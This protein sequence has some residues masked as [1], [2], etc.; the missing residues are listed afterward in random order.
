M[1]SLRLSGGAITH[2]Q[3][4][5]SLLRE[6]R[7]LCVRQAGVRAGMQTVDEGYRSG[8]KSGS[9]RRAD[10]CDGRLAMDKYDEQVEKLLPCI[11]ELDC[12]WDQIDSE[13]RQFIHVSGCPVVFRPTVASALRELG[14]QLDRVKEEKEKANG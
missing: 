11:G 6:V 12:Y 9:P 10:N 7:S 4:S 1:L 13:R 3:T 5:A 2:A 14:E 8:G